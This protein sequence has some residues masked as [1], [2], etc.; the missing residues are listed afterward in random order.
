RPPPAAPA[1]RAGTPWRRGQVVV[2]QRGGDT[3]VKRV[4]GLPG[5]HVTVRDRILING[6][7]VPHC[8]AGRY[9]RVADGRLVDGRLAVEYLERE[10]YLALYFTGDRAELVE[11]TVEPNSLFVLGDDR[12]LSLDSRAWSGGAVTEVL[13]SVERVLVRPVK[14]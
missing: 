14:S 7:E 2:V 4:I 3:H 10:T 13:G 9:F 1:G 12:G 11:Q 6:W 8:D 5:D